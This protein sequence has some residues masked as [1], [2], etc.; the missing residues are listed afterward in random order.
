MSVDIEQIEQ[1]VLASILSEKKAIAVFVENSYEVDQVFSDHRDLA[2]LI[3]QHFHDFHII[4]S[5]EILNKIC[6]KLPNHALLIDQL[7]EIELVDPDSEQIEYWI[8]Q[9]I[10][11][12]R[13]NI[14][15]K[16]VLSATDALSSGDVNLATK[17]LEKGAIES[18]DL[19]NRNQIKVGDLGADAKERYQEYLFIKENPDYHKRIPTGFKGLDDNIGGVGAG[20]LNIML[21]R[22]GHG[23]SMFLLNVAYNAWKDYEK[24]VFFFSY[25]MP[26]KQ[27]EKRLDSR[28][29][30][31]DYNKIKTGNLADLEIKRYEMMLKDMSRRNKQAVFK[32]FQPPQKTTTSLVRSLIEKYEKTDGIKPDLIVLDYMSLM[33]PTRTTKDQKEHDKLGEIALDCR[34]L[35]ID[36]AVPIWTACQIN[37]A[38]VKEKQIDTSNVFG[39]DQIAHHADMML[40]LKRNENEIDQ[41]TNSMEIQATKVRDGACKN[42]EIYYDF[43]FCLMCDKSPD[44]FS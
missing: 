28:H 41:F 42:I 37:R 6:S 14:V 21:G 30:M 5:Y 7:T 15:Q 22:P 17:L 39:S 2:K 31:L 36:L 18:Q 24:N 8:K 3:F 16:A 25:E 10:E 34:A 33:A 19:L 23:K 12:N 38:G 29:A 4:P 44:G 20:E 26:I 13:K 40:S 35:G 11:S 9:L 32:I 1:R 43:S 27:V